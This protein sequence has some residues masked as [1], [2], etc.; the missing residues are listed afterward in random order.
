MKK[1]IA[2]LLLVLI[3]ILLTSCQTGAGEGTEQTDN[4]LYTRTITLCALSPEKISSLE[5]IVPL[6]SQRLEHM[7][8]GG[9]CAVNGEDIALTVTSDHEIMRDE[10]DDI[11]RRL[12]MSGELTFGD[13]DGEHH[14]T[15]AD[16]ESVSCRFDE[17][18]YIDV[19]LKEESMPKYAELVSQA[20]EKWQSVNNFVALSCDEE[21]LAKVTVGADDGTAKTVSFSGLLTKDD[22]EWIVYAYENP[23]PA[24]LTEKNKK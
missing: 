6:M 24:A 17:R 3:I 8:Y 13:S 21:V 4:A 2:A 10:R 19:T 15:R 23:L 18:Y 1:R 7:G 14:L 20:F 16:F 11:I 22:A 9:N 12:C 5:D